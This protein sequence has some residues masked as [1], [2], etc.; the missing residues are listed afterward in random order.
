VGYQRGTLE[1]SRAYV[2]LGASTHGVWHELDRVDTGFDAERASVAFVN[3]H[4]W[5]DSTTN[6]INSDL[7]RRGYRVF[8]I[9]HY[10]TWMSVS[11][12][13]G[14]PSVHLHDILPAVGKAV[15]EARGRSGVET[16]ILLGHSA[17]AQLVA[18][19]Q[20]VAENG[21]GVGQGREKL[22]PLPERLREHHCPPADGVFIMDGHLGDGAKGL[23]DLGPQVV[24]ADDP[25]R[26]DPTVDMLDP[27]NGY[28]SESGEASSYSAEFLDRFFSAQADRMRSLID[29]NQDAL[30]AIEDESG[31]FPD[32]NAFV[33]IDARSR[34]WR[35]DPS[36][37]SHTSEEWP[38]VRAPAGE[39][40]SNRESLQRIE[41]VREVKT[42]DYEPP[43]TYAGDEV[44]PTSV[45]RFLSTRAVRP[46]DEYRLTASSIEGLDWNS[47][48]AT[49]PGNLEGISAPLLIIQMTGHYLVV[50]GELFRN[51]AGSADT[52]LKYIHGANHFGDPIGPEYG[53][54]RTALVDV[55]EEWTTDRYVS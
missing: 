10:S 14:R 17:G 23:T 45:R 8:A 35:P 43:I 31:R 21:I 26:R 19:Y 9:D 37:L 3:V 36:I 34:V 20:N 22:L 16:V 55:I 30:E 2:D 18:L 53:D 40:S 1:K 29:R 27:A 12:A 44:E 52:T 5:I 25:R 4:P 24:D 28:A 51:H 6:R 11:W 50:H 33:L 39:S 48:N 7:A 32:D 15:S 54:T 46:T 42:P 47:S 49:T 13:T 41:S 38:L